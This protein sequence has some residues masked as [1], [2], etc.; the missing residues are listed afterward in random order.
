MED[1]VMTG[2][3]IIWMRRRWIADTRLT[4]VIVA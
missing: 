4:N 1:L 3:L 2:I